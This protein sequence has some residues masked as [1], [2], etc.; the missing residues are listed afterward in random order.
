MRAVL[1]AIF[2]LLAGRIAAGDDL[3]GTFRF[4]LFTA[5]ASL[6]WSYRRNPAETILL[7]NMMEGLVE[8]G[9]NFE[10]LPALASRWEVSDDKLTYTF[11]LKK[12]ARWT[13]GAPLTAADFAFAWQRLLSPKTHSEYSSYL[14]DIE[15][16]EAYS[17]GR[18]RDFSRVAIKALDAGR[19]QVKLRRPSPI[20]LQALHLYVTFP[21]RKDLI[22][23]HPTDWWKPPFLATLGPYRLMDLGGA[24]GEITL[25]RNADYHGVPPAIAT[26]RAVIEPDPAKARALAR[27]GKIDLLFAVTTSDIVSFTAASQGKWVAKQFDAVNT[28][29]LGFVPRVKPVNKPGVRKALALAFD[30]AGIPNALENGFV[31]ADAIIPKS[32]LG[33]EPAA[34]PF[35]GAAAR[36]A[37]LDAGYDKPEKFPKLR[38][39]Y[40]ESVYE[41]IAA[42]I[43]DQAKKNLGLDIELTAVPSAKYDQAIASGRYHMFLETWWADYPD[44]S[45]FLRVLVSGS[46]LNRTAWSDSGYDTLVKKGLEAPDM[47]TRMKSFAEAQKLLLQSAA[48]VIPLYHSK[49]TTLLSSRVD[50][51]EIDPRVSHLY[52]K[53]VTLK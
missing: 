46:R 19:L 5:P 45:N 21:Q 23:K 38:L 1:A 15:N 11:F 29:Y 28:A 52:F 17:K 9:P 12:G 53:N 34:L 51:F 44:P 39:V 22:E 35:D 30:R 48:V 42:Y 6:D 13:D 37:M 40:V 2:C 4:R 20:F 32:L 27:D 49:T 33:Y 16:A 18:I 41:R 36:R 31:P 3:A 43:R 24:N 7:M 8:V 47:L 50:K 25:S 10:P 14:N 26:V